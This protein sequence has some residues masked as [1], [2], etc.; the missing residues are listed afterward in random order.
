MTEPR[1]F[2]IGTKVV[3]TDGTPGVVLF[4]DDKRLMVWVEWDGYT[5]E[6]ERKSELVHASD[7]APLGEWVPLREE[8]F[9][10]EDDL[11]GEAVVAKVVVDLANRI[12][13]GE[14]PQ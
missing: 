2:H 7:G 9:R 4:A 11:P 14:A 3:W 8:V 5:A 1:D 12:I 13:R 10:N 6:K